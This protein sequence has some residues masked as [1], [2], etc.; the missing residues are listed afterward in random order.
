MSVSWFDQLVW[1]GLLVFLVWWLWQFRISI[2]WQ[3]YRAHRA[4]SAHAKKAYRHYCKL[5]RTGT[6]IRINV[7]EKQRY[8][9]VL[10]SGGS[11]IYGEIHF[12]TLAQLFAVCELPTGGRF[13][14]LGCGRGHVVLA[15]AL[16]HDF[17]MVK[18]VEL[19]PSLYAQAQDLKRRYDSD[20]LAD[21][22]AQMQFY[23]TDMLAHDWSDA[24]VVFV[25]AT[26]FVGEFWLQVEARLTAL[27]PGTLVIV[28]SKK[29]SDA[30]FTCRLSS[31]GL[32]S[33]G[34]NSVAVYE[35]IA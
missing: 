21:S 26:A 16:L 14:D 1:L 4:S 10:L 31:Y 5:L 7:A 8:A 25:N 24:T 19:L 29:L 30:F 18:G 20:S 13:Y 22:R 12:F 17:A 9:K 11:L 34:M 35:R 32:M 15:A 27:A 3:Q 28:T 2:Y 6:G 23:Q 33:W